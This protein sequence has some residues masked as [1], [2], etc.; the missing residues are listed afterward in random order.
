MTVYL[1]AV[2]VVV[3]TGCFLCSGC[4]T[5]RREFEDASATTAA[6]NK[7][8]KKELERLI[9]RVENLE[10]RLAQQQ[11]TLADLKSF[12][13]KIDGRVDQKDSA[14]FERLSKQIA[15]TQKSNNESFKKLRREI[16]AKIQEINR[17]LGSLSNSGSSP[18]G[19]EYQTGFTHVVAENESLWTIQRKYSEYGMTIDDIKRANNIPQDSDVIRAGQ[20]L[21]IPTK[22]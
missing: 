17:L 22:R 21:F 11:E 5:T 1:K 10:Y 20:E 4:V 13:S 19:D 7:R 3:L 18:G 9:E 15:Q 12:L 6:A 2:V 14:T 16:N 8:T